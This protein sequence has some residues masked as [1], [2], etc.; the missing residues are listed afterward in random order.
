MTNSF[1]LKN[2]LSPVSM[3][4]TNGSIPLLLHPLVADIELDDAVVG[5]RLVG[6]EEEGGRMEKGGGAGAGEGRRLVSND[7]YCQRLG[8]RSAHGA[9]SLE[10]N[11]RTTT[12]DRTRHAVHKTH[13]L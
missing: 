12:R 13:K 7:E 6:G 5:H 11:N 10:T 1:A 2:S 9:G 3:K 8:D 4:R